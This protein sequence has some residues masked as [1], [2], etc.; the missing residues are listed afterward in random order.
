M[1]QEVVGIHILKQI[2]F[3][4]PND[5]LANRLRKVYLRGFP[6]VKIYQ[7]AEFT[8]EFIP[9]EQ[10]PQRLHTPQPNVY[11]SHLTRIEQLAALFQ[12]QGID[13]TNLTHAYDFIAQTADGQETL[14]T[15]L[16]PVVER[17]HIPAKL[18]KL[19]YE[20]LFGEQLKAHIASQGFG[21]NPEAQALTHTST[22]GI[23]DLVNDGIH[24]VHYGF[25]TKKGMRVFRIAN[26]TPGFPYYAAPQAYAS[27]QIL[28]EANEQ[29]TQMKVHVVQSPGQKAL[30]RYFPSGDIHSGDVRPA[31]KGEVFR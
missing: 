12:K 7:H 13:I 10:I 29:G 8:D 19:N 20:S 26:L 2:P 27:I 24:R 11:Q 3:F 14:W 23:F 15:M 18:G 9:A 17:W 31:T 5:S 16:P 1:N 25:I 6:D 28:P 30:Y 22:S 4:G 21:I